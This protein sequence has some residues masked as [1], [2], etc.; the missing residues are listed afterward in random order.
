MKIS[1]LAINKP[2]K[3]YHDEYNL[4]IRNEVMDFDERLEIKT[5][6]CKFY[7]NPPTVFDSK[8]NKTIDENSGSSNCSRC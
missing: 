2:G 6:Y 5:I 1:L 8:D 7:W 3:L 4:I